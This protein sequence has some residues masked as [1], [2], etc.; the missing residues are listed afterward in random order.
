[1]LTILAPAKLNL[2]LDVVGKRADGY[3]LIRSVMQTVSL[4]DRI[5]LIPRRDGVITLTSGGKAL[6][7]AEEN[8]AFRAALL[9]QQTSAAGKGVDILLHKEIPLAA[10]LGGGSADAAAVLFGL[11]RLWDI[12]APL[13]ELQ[14]LGLSLGA[15]V[16][17][18][19][20]GGT[21][22]VEGIGEIVN[23]LPPLTGVYFLL[24]KEGKKPSTGEM[25]RRLDEHPPGEK[26]DIAGLVDYLQ[27]NRTGFSAASFDNVFWPAAEEENP[28]IVGIK[29]FLLET[30][31]ERVGLSG[32]GPTLFGLFRE[33]K[34]AEQAFA[35]CR[36]RFHE[37]YLTSPLQSGPAVYRGGCDGGKTVTD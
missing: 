12:P 6:P 9:M 33:R 25:Y 20:A 32:A 18:C 17:F 23:P 37:V 34:R 28:L 8:L 21:A 22:L 5:T 30:G 14:K 4:Y 3:H 1:M 15:D 11:A 29:K 19:L 16:P 2:N 35:R 27:G 26:P 7:A 13:K 36:G 31:A 24:V 10:G